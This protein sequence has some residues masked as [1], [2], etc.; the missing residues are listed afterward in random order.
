MGRSF[1]KKVTNPLNI[2]AKSLVDPFGLF[3][4]PHGTGGGGGGGGSQP[5]GIGTP[6]WLYEHMGKDD[7]IKLMFENAKKPFYEEVPVAPEF[8]E[9]YAS[10]LMSAGRK[11]ADIAA[12]NLRQGLA[13][14]G[15]G[16]LGS[17]LSMSA[18]S[19]S[20][21][22]LD[23]VS[24]GAQLD[25][26]KYGQDISKYGKD[27]GLYNTKFNIFDAQRAALVNALTF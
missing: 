21:S 22:V 9:G 18:A 3:S 24:R 6:E 10:E 19:R 16:G 5:P 8:E 15:A 4:D 20:G 1:W 7:D 27:I 25:V 11:E 17:A 23:A 14:R 2:S 13:G 26:Q 12:G